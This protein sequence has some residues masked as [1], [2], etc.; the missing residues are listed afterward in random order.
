[1]ISRWC[2]GR[3]VIRYHSTVS[4]TAT[5]SFLHEHTGLCLWNRG[6]C[7]QN[8]PSHDFQC[9]LLWN[10]KAHKDAGE[11]TQSLQLRACHFT[12]RNLALQTITFC[13][14]TLSEHPS[15]SIQTIA[16][17]QI[18]VPFPLDE[19]YVLLHHRESAT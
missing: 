7:Q 3:P 18:V 10:G 9:T 6:K 8:R 19:Q 17:S 13:S 5:C 1:M 2:C 4:V 11:V 15:N 16:I 14:P 12:R